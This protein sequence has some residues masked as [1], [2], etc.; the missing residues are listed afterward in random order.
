MSYS[1]S[2]PGTII[3]GAGERRKLAELLPAGPVLFVA[4]R[5]SASRIQSEIVPALAGGVL[6]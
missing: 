6:N 3:F 2:F 1:L 5:H 4:G